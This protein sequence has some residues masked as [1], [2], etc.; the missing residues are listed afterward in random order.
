VVRKEKS[1][2]AL[3]VVRDFEEIVCNL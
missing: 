3:T 1:D 2:L